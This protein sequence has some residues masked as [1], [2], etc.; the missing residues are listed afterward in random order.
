MKFELGLGREVQDLRLVVTAHLIIDLEGDG[1]FLRGAYYPA[2]TGY[3]DIKSYK[4]GTRIRVS[5]Q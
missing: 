2:E 3:A 5:N 4:Y 1:I